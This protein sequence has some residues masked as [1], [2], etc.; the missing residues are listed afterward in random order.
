LDC[1]PW[2]IRNLDARHGRFTGR[3]HRI[4]RA[5]TSRLVGHLGRLRVV[6]WLN[7]TLG[8]DALMP[9]PNVGA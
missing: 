3:M 7:S 2:K 6:D 9:A 8:K 4:H 1:G 5:D